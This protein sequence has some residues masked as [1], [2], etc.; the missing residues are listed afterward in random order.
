MGL[1]LE[2]SN[3]QREILRLLANRDPRVQMDA[4]LE[5]GVALEDLLLKSL[6]TEN[7]VRSLYNVK[8]ATDRGSLKFPIAPNQGL[9]WVV[10]RLGSIARNFIEGTEIEIPVDAVATRWSFPLDYLA[11]YNYSPIEYTANEMRDSIVRA[12]EAW[13]WQLIRW[14]ANNAG[15]G[16]AVTWPNVSQK[17]QVTDGQAGS[18]YFSKQLL[19]A[20]S[21]YFEK[22]NMK[23]RYLIGPPEMQND[24]RNWGET[25]I[26]P[27]TRREVFVGGGLPQI[28]G[29]ELKVMSPILTYPTVDD[30]TNRTPT[31]IDRLFDANDLL[32]TG[33]KA[34]TDG[35]VTQ[36]NNGT[37]Q[38]AFGIAEDFGIMG[39]KETLRVVPDPTVIT[40]WQMGWIARE[41]VGF[42]IV[43]SIKI[44]MMIVDRT[45]SEST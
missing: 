4:A 21:L 31:T 7:T 41:R 28:W 19:S 20:A 8:T 24:I 37:L 6:P 45:D 10:S 35:Q 30:R 25:Q 17:I 38:V 18:G 23:M 36:Y 15:A 9:A 26:D 1:K 14:A 43:D 32:N 27:V 34:W 39:E 16:G 11:D 40:E 12:E 33:A 2:L 29:T 22:R 42:A 44:L 5:V 3:E 13:G